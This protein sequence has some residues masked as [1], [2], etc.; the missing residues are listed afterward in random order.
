LPLSRSARTLFREQKSRVVLCKSAAFAPLWRFGHSLNTN[1]PARAIIAVN[2]TVLQQ[3][4]TVSNQSPVFRKVLRCAS[5]FSRVN[6]TKA[7]HAGR[8]FTDFRAENKR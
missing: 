2:V 6:M 5:R 3:E 7:Q 4:L 1:L 8:A